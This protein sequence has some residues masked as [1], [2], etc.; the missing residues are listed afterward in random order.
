MRPHSTE[1][2]LVAAWSPSLAGL[3]ALYRSYSA[4][5]PNTHALHTMS[6]FGGKSS[7]RSESTSFHQSAFA[8]ASA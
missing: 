2:E 4:A 6:S 8:G 7:M 5:S 3:S 1:S